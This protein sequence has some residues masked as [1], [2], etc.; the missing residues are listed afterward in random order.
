MHY[1]GFRWNAESIY[2]FVGSYCFGSKI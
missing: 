2:I 1:F